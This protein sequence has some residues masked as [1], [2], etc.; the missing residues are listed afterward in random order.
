MSEPNKTK[1]EKI[2]DVD[3]TINS[4]YGIDEEKLHEISSEQKSEIQAL[5]QLKLERITHDYHGHLRGRIMEL[6][7]PKDWEAFYI[8]PNPDPNGKLKFIFDAAKYHKDQKSYE[9]RYA[10]KVLGIS[11]LAIEGIGTVGNDKVKL[12]EVYAY[13]LKKD[14]QKISD[15]NTIA[16]SYGIILK[17]IK[18]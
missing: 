11:A 10:A 4:Y 7:N 17:P 8:I 3:E 13:H 15:L 5:L 6:L 12:R 9:K 16:H 1:S 18:C 2:L 14:L